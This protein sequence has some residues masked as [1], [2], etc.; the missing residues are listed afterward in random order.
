[1]STPFL[2]AR[3]LAKV[4]RKLA[5]NDTVK[6]RMANRYL[7]VITSVQFAGQSFPLPKWE[8]ATANMDTGGGAVIGMPT[9]LTAAY[10][11]TTAMLAASRNLS[12]VY[13]SISNLSHV[14]IQTLNPS[15]QVMSVFPPITF[16]F[17]SGSGG[18]AGGQAVVQSEN[19]YFSHGG[20][21][22]SVVV[23]M[24]GALSSIPTAF[25][26]SQPFFRGRYTGF[27]RGRNV[28][29][30]TDS[31]TCKDAKFVEK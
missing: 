10:W 16:I 1:M 23:S 15:V 3:E 21:P 24:S 17:R 30:F 8:H 4:A 9:G 12:V 13:V 26:P 5:W 27:D 28:F 25:W 14:C 19:L 31:L 20:V 6:N 22:C 11:N 29:L 18:G 7:A 2:D